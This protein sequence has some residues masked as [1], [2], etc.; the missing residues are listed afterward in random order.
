MKTITRRLATVALVA[1]FGTTTAYAAGGTTTHCQI[2]ANGV[3]DALNTCWFFT[4]AEQDP[5]LKKRMA[6]RCNHMTGV[7]RQLIQWCNSNITRC[8]KNA[9]S[10]DFDVDV[11]LR[12]G[13]KSNIVCT[14]R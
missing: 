13:W 5:Q 4:N 11:F 6:K 1:V 2:V 14:Y 3:Q 9:V 7:G 12:F 8:K 10:Y